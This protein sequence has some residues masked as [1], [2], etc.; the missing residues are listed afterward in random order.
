MF[1]RFNKRIVLPLAA[2]ASLFQFACR[3]RPAAITTLLGEGHSYLT[4][5]SGDRALLGNSSTSFDFRAPDM[6]L[7]NAYL[8]AFLSANAYSSKDV[9]L[10]ELK[11]LGFT[12]DAGTETEEQ[13][14]FMDQDATSQQNVLSRTGFRY[15]NT[16]AIWAENKD[17]AFLA[18]RGTEP[19]DIADI[20][21]D[22]WVSQRN[23]LTQEEEEVGQ[24]A[25]DPGSNAGETMQTADA[26]IRVHKGFW[27][28][29]DIVWKDIEARAKRILA[30]EAPKER[31]AKMAALDKLVQTMDAA[32]GQLDQKLNQMTDWRI[33]LQGKKNFVRQWKT[34]QSNSAQ[35]LDLYQFINK[36]WTSWQKPV[37]ITG[38][39]L[40]GA[41]ATVAAW[42]LLK[43][44]V[45]VKGLY[46]FGSPR[47]GNHAFVHD[48]RVRAFDRGMKIPKG[49]GNLA[50]FVHHMDIVARVPPIMGWTSV[51][52]DSTMNPF[53]DKW[54]HVS[55]M[56]YLTGAPGE[57]AELWFQGDPAFEANFA[58]TK[59][60]LY[61]ASLPVDAWKAW[62]GDHDNTKYAEKIERLQFGE[63]IACPPH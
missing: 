23:L 34:M 35:R 29:L 9:A 43:L 11:R 20:I 25:P 42:R 59:V 40:G 39:S 61:A 36:R 51:I 62:G 14:T 13:L 22:I 46:T 30:E 53:L 6:T 41:L 19:S 56:R 24:L 21:S 12:G 15:A 32:P 48:L 63:H 45:N 38:H 7:K 58:Q 16:Q 55:R 3:S 50:R 17:G 26:T 44:G 37:W 4:V 57:E 49:E 60:P 28:A 1:V 10:N 8:M 54:D 31:D 27:Y 52:D 5:C 18:F 2:F 33:P 47:A